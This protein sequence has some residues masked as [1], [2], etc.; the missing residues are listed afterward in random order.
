MYAPQS[1]IAA[2]GGVLA[3]AE[4]KDDERQPAGEDHFA[5]APGRICKACGGIIEPGQAARRRGE[6]DWEHRVGLGT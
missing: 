4:I 1:R 5:H 3:D 2:E 6:S